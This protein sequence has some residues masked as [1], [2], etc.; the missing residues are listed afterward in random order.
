MKRN[1]RS[2]VVLV[3]VSGLCVACGSAL[4]QVASRGYTFEPLSG[5]TLT[6]EA[7]GSVLATPAS[8]QPRSGLAVSFDATMGALLR[9][10]VQHWGDPHINTFGI[11]LSKPD[12]SSGE[13]LWRARWNGQNLVEEVELAGLG[14]RVTSIDLYDASGARVHPLRGYDFSA[15]LSLTSSGGGGPLDAEAWTVGMRDDGAEGLRVFRT[16]TRPRSV[17]V[18]PPG[19]P[20]FVVPNVATVALR[21]VCITSPCPGDGTA[22]LRLSAGV[23]GGSPARSVEVLDAGVDIAGISVDEPGVNFAEPR[24]VGAWETNGDPHVDG[25]SVRV[26]RGPRARMS[27]QNNMRTC[28]NRP[29]PIVVTYPVGDSQAFVKSSFVQAVERTDSQGQVVRIG[30]TFSELDCNVTYLPSSNVPAP[31]AGARLVALSESGAALADT[32]LAGGQFF[33]LSGVCTEED[34]TVWSISVDEPGVNIW[35]ATQIAFTASPGQMRTSTGQLVLGVRR[36]LVKQLGVQLVPQA[37]AQGLRVVSQCGACNC[38]AGDE[39]F[40]IGTVGPRACDS[41]DFNND[42]LFPDDSDLVDFLSVLA[43]GGCSQSSCNDIDFNND[44]LFPDDSDL[45]AL[46]TVLAGGECE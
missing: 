31:G 22:T 24:I 20:A 33:N 25:A 9:T 27:S 10:S 43:G 6:R 7:N 23:Q 40:M 32:V 18:S 26:D 12:G 2:G 21:I 38:E 44:G 17:L 45:L 36:V 37:G 46:L 4:A 3:A 14:V 29:D 19:E 41:I 1:A 34:D 16:T 28:T 42:G 11:A 15:M 8:G 30:T 35:D 5:S 13:G 39:G